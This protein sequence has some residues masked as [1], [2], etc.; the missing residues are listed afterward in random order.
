[1]DSER[2]IALEAHYNAI[3][4]TLATK[5]DIEALRAEIHKWL[6]GT[7]IGLF[8]GFAGLFIAMGQ[9]LKPTIAPQQGAAPPIVIYLPQPPQK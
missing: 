2:L 6:V 1:M 3:L 4:P 5:A 9:I 7:L 8:I